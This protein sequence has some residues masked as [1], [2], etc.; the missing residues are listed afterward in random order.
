MALGMEPKYEEIDHV[1]DL[2]FVNVTSSGQRGL[3]AVG[4]RVLE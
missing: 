4:W 2:V 1:Y 3:V